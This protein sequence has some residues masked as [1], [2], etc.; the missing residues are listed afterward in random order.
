MRRKNL[1]A[2]SAAFLIL[3]SLAPL[4]IIFKND[5]HFGANKVAS[6]APLL[7]LRDFRYKELENG[8]GGV[9]VLGSLGYHFAD[10]DEIEK[11][12]LLKKEGS[13]MTTVSSQKAVKRGDETMMSGG[14]SYIRSDGYKLFTDKSR[15]FQ[16]S[17]MLHIETPFRFDGQKFVAFGDSSEI[18]MKNKKIA[19]NSVR[20]KLNY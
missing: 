8:T 17:Q 3:A 13:Y 15:Y 19:I 20:A 7:T 12:V 14:V 16:K 9:E 18:D 1:F 2:Q 10:R 5:T 6:T 4:S 11:L